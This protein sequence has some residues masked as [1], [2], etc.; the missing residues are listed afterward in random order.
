MGVTL[1]FLAGTVAATLH[2]F[3]LSGIDYRL[4]WA[5]P[6]TVLLM[7]FVLGH[8]VAGPRYRVVRGV[9]YATV[10]WIAVLTLQGALA[11]ARSSRT[12]AH[13]LQRGQ[14]RVYTTQEAVWYVT[15]GQA[16]DFIAK[17]VPAGEKLFTMPFDTL[18]N[19]LTG[20]DQPTRQWVYFQH[21]IIPEE[22]ERQV[23]QDLEREKVNWVL[24]SNRAISIEGGLG[25]LGRD[26][27]TVLWKYI[28]K[29]Y[30]PA[31]R[32]GQWSSSPSWAWNHGV[33][34]F[35]RKVP[36]AH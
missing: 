23:I 6:S 11:Q 13:L 30:Q 24:V 15:V 14:N 3:L 33:I 21:M 4:Y 2:E 20:R 34:I 29:N 1:L 10:F 12:P 28:D 35:K 22:Q 16:C 17:N 31:A 26:Y 19:Y 36:F 7:I 25:L 32:F 5:F 27:C 9:L 8:A 18:Y